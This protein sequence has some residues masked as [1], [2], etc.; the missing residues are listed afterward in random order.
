MHLIARGLP[1]TTTTTTTTKKPRKT[2]WHKTVTFGN[3]D[4][5]L[6]VCSSQTSSGP[7]EQKPVQAN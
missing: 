1:K 3:E 5:F 7:M 6:C 4:N 2:K